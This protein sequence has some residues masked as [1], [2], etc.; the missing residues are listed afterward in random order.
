MHL[1]WRLYVLYFLFLFTADMWSSRSLFSIYGAKLKTALSK[2]R[3]LYA[4]NDS[5]RAVT[6]SCIDTRL[7]NKN[8]SGK[9]SKISVNHRCHHQVGSKSINH[10]PLAWLKEGQKVTLVAVIGGSRSDLSKTRKTGGNLGNVA[11]R[12]LIYKAT[13]QCKR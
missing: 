9:V 2:T 10:S 13:Y 7:Q 11:E 6:T 8:T 3:T 1:F 12:V 5:Q 4:A